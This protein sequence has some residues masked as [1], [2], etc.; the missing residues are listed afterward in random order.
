M[1][2]NKK[3]IVYVS[4]VIIA[5]SYLVFDHFKNGTTNIY[6][7]LFLVLITVVNLTNDKKSRAKQYHQNQNGRRLH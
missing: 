3:I 2:N 4:I 7:I 1:L 6:F 5:L